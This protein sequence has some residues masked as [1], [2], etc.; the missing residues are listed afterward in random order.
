MI[1][2]KNQDNQT[3]WNTFVL[4][5]FVI[6]FAM[7]AYQTLAIEKQ[8]QEEIIEIY[9]FLETNGFKGVDVKVCWNCTYKIADYVNYET[10]T[11]ETAPAMYDI[12]NQII[13]LRPEMITDSPIKNLWHE[14][15]HYVWFEILNKTQRETY[16]QIYQKS[17]KYPTQYALEGGVKEDFAESFAYYMLGKYN[18][19]PDD[20][21]EY[22]IKLRN[23]DVI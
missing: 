22:I 23:E 10:T 7:Q 9:S 19:L 11:K 1:I 8:N 4:I 3:V 18:Q 17:T 6:I 12:E 13:I 21:K 2:R 14:Y 15:G 20:R 16:K 5:S